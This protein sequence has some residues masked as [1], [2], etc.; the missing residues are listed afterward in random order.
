MVPD[1]E[2]LLTR[3]QTGAALRASGFPV[4]DKSLATLACRGGGPAFR[5]FGA[6]P[7]YRWGDA[8]AWAQSRLSPLIGSTS[9][10]DAGAAATGQ[11][12]RRKLP[13]P[14]GATAV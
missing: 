14:D 4:A 12:R 9:E 5:R 13:A 6:R 1:S 11:P 3:A 8:L 2:A 7:L 10:L